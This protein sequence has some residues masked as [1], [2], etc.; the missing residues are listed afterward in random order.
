MTLLKYEDTITSKALQTISRQKHR[1][2]DKHGNSMKFKEL[3]KK[4]KEIIKVE[5][6][7][8]LN[9]QIKKAGGK[10]MQWMQEA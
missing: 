6:T 8:Q 10:G 1:E 2:Y 3:K 7:K 4:Q 5:V 9:K